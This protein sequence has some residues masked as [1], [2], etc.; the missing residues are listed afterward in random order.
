MQRHGGKREDENDEQ[1]HPAGEFHEGN[2]PRRGAR[3]VKEPVVGKE[4]RADAEVKEI[5][6]SSLSAAQD[7]APPKMTR[8]T[9]PQGR[10]MRASEKPPSPAAIAKRPPVMRTHQLSTTAK[11]N[12]GKA[13]TAVRNAV[14]GAD[15]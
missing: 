9:R 8:N 3:G 2:K 10:R 15:P 6:A 4:E 1:A 7:A 12:S 14:A 11:T 5:S 13:S